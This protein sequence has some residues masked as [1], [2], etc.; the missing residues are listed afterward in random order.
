MRSKRRGTNSKKRGRGGLKKSSSSINPHW[1]L[2]KSHRAQK[3]K[4]K[5]IKSYSSK[6]ELPIRE[7]LTNLRDSS[8]SRKTELASS[9][10]SRK[11]ALKS[12]DLS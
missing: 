11:E 9:R 12:S 8:K 7:K 5:D 1:T 10:M 2:S 4:S 6:R 3:E